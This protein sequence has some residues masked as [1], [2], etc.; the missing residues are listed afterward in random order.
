MAMEVLYPGIM[1]ICVIR[2]DDQKPVNSFIN[3]KTIVHE[4]EEI[5]I[6]QRG[7]HPRI[8]AAGIHVGKKS[9]APG[10]FKTELVKEFVVAGHGG[11][12]G[13]LDKVKSMTQDY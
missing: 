2:F 12:D 8:D 10:A 9:P 1:T 3:Q 7:Y 4:Q 13:D 5:F 6:K 11:K